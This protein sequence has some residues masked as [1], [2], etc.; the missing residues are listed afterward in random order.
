MASLAISSTTPLIARQT[1][2][3]NTDLQRLLSTIPAAGSPVPTPSPEA[4]QVDDLPA[5]GQ[6]SGEISFI[7]AAADVADAASAVTAATAQQAAAEVGKAAPKKP[8]Y[9]AAPAMSE[10]EQGQAILQKGHQGEAVAETQ[11][12]LT[13][14]GYPVVDNGMLGTT[15]EGK[16]KHFQKD[17]D[18]SITGQIGKTTMRILRAVADKFIQATRAGGA[19]LNSAKQVVREMGTVGRCYAGVARAVGR[20]L[21]VNLWGGSAYMAADQ[22]RD[23]SKFKEVKN[24]SVQDLHKMPEGTVVVWDRNPR[25]GSRPGHIHGH[26]AILDGKGGEYSDHYRRNMFAP[27]YAG[28][29]HSVFVPV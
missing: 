23:S 14:A 7:D 22:L 17:N 24:V 27:H 5:S 18:I 28:G 15:T 25:A 21:G 4:D 8:A 2:E 16:I 6:A 13:E 10:I 20:A 29:Q 19:L 26:I 1:V 11:R 3:P 12:L 9:E